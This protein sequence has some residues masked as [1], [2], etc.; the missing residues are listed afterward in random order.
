MKNTQFWGIST[1]QII[2]QG[3]KLN[4]RSSQ[5]IKKRN[6]LQENNNIPIIQIKS[7]WQE[8]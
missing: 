5:T 2:L 1:F 3:A 7:D 4:M 6:N 8:S